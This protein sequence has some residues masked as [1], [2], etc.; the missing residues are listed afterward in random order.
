MRVQLDSHNFECLSK[1]VLDGEEVTFVGEANSS[2]SLTVPAAIIG[3]L[4]LDG[5]EE[6]ETN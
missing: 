5:N 1:A 4:F 6:E 3:N 2:I